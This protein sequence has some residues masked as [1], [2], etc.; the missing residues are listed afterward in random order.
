[1]R[2]KRAEENVF[3]FTFVSF[4]SV[5]QLLKHMENAELSSYFVIR[6]GRRSLQAATM[7]FACSFVA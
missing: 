3:R 7:V 5:D 6:A 2:K 4:S 1:M